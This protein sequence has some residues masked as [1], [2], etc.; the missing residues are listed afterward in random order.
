[1][2]LCWDCEYLT[3]ETIL[4]TGGAMRLLF[5]HTT[6]GTNEMTIN[7]DFVHWISGNET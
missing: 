1:M 7:W 5:S 6:D 3:A 4:G 2:K